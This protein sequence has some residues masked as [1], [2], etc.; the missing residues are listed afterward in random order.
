VIIVNDNGDHESASEEEVE[1]VYVDEA[2]EDED[3]TRCEFEQVAALV[4][5]Q[6]L[7]VQMKEA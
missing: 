7:S 4:V 3:H 2:H 1:E 6:I 5:A